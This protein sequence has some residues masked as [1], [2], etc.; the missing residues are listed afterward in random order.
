M[1]RRSL[2]FAAS[3]ARLCRRAFHSNHAQAMQQGMPQTQM[4]ALSIQKME[5]AKISVQT[6]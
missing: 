4:G 1:D 6:L 2:S 3:L 5:I